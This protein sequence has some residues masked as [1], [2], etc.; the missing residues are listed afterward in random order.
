MK[1]IFKYLSILLS[2]ALL[3][4]ISACNLLMDPLEETAEAGLGI[5]V[6]FPTK[7]VAGQPMTINGNG[8]A[9]AR[10]IEFP[11]GVSVTDFEIVSNQM[12]RVVAPA[13]IAADGGVIKVV[14]EEGEAVSRLPLTLGST[15]VSGFSLQ[16]GETLKGGESI[17]VYGT[18]LQFVCEAELPDAEGNPMTLPDECFYRK[19]ENKLVITIPRKVF[20]G[21]YVGK[22]RTFDGKEFLLP[23]L[24]YEPGAEGGHWEKKEVMIWENDGSHG[25]VSWSSDY[26]FA[27]EANKTGEEI[28]AIPDDVWAK[29]KEGTF[30]VKVTAENPQI[31]ITTGWWSTTWTGNDFMPGSEGLTDNG[32][33]TWTLE[34]KLA[35]DP[36]MDVIDVQHLLVT[37]DR[38]T[39]VSLFF[40]EDVWI[41]GGGGHMEIVKSSIWKNDGSHG[42]VS[43]SSDYRFANES[44]KTG[45]EIYAIPDDVWEKMKGG[46]FYVD[47][48]AEN[49]QIRITTGWWS[50]TWTGNDFMPGSE[51]LTDNGDGTWTLAVTL[52]DDPIMDVIDVQHL[53]VT[54]DR[55][56]PVELYFQ[57][58]VWVGGDPTPKEELIWE[59][60]G[61]HGAVSWSSDYRFAAD[62]NKTGEEIYAIPDDVWAQ[63]KAGTFYVDV[64][65]ENPQIRITTGWWS[66]TWTGNDFMPGSEG[67]TDNGDGTWTLAV[68]LGDDP[69]MDVI[70]VQHLLVTG[71]R[72]TPK[73]LYFLK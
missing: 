7:V 12:I 39:P 63:M 44:N 36:I 25:A 59:N 65:A 68:T 56:T 67:L 43:W 26:R 55:F 42:A 13:G 18:D 9:T 50:T 19:G 28:Y 5:K 16:A 48:E 73:K 15:S 35:G 37:G 47:V 53:L 2:V 27:A 57:E 20:D 64:E 3:G 69:I 4:S 41:E 71:D 62:A 54:G 49:P 66:T 34:V 14:T 22:L 6:F 10:S 23:E 30:Y 70:D 1:K 24:K 58:E 51:G 17:E 29:M 52:G 33:G 21:T 46:T 45:E 38:F 60:D 11:N 72:F 31:R 8:F 32:D 61:S 40:V